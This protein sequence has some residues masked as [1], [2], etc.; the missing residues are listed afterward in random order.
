M[1]AKVIKR[2]SD[3][4]AILY[5]EIYN[6]APLDMHNGISNDCIR[7]EG[8]SQKYTKGVN[9]SGLKPRTPLFF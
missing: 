9:F 8:I 2:S 7:L 3:K 4:K 6:R 5:N 1:F